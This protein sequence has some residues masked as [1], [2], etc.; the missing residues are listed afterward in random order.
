MR[1]KNQKIKKPNWF[2][3]ELTQIQRKNKEMADLNNFVK[4]FSNP[5]RPTTK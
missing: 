3:P 1:R 2:S 4:V 5:K